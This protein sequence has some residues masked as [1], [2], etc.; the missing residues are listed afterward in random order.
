MFFYGKTIL[1]M[2]ADPEAPGPTAAA[3]VFISCILILLTLPFSL[4][5]CIK[6]K[7]IWYR[8]PHILCPIQS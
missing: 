1:F 6:V 4:C 5:C 7:Y 8:M 2:S 3:L